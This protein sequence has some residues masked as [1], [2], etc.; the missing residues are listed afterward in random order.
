MGGSKVKRHCAT[1]QVLQLGLAFSLLL[2]AHA[3]YH[4]EC[5]LCIL[6][7]LEL[8]GTWVR[9]K[10]DKGRGTWIMQD[11]IEPY[12]T[13]DSLLQELVRTLKL[14]MVL[15]INDDGWICHCL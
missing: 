3:G 12:D 2:C 13:P 6:H 15:L 7:L 11:L 8:E 5:N 14:F 9:Q 1:S 4:I 10:V